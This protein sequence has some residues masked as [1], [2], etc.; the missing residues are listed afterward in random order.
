MSACVSSDHEGTH[1]LSEPD[2]SWK[3]AKIEDL[4]SEADSLIADKKYESAFKILSDYDSDNE[5]P[6]IVIKKAE[7]CINYYVGSIMYEIFALADLEKDQDIM[8]LRE[9]DGNSFMYVFKVREVLNNLIEKYPDNGLLYKALGS[10]YYEVF[11]RYQDSWHDTKTVLFF[12]I[13]DNYERAEELNQ[14]DY[15]SYYRTGF[16]YLSLED[17]DKAVEY[18]NKSISLNENYGDSHYH[19]AAAYFNKFDFKPALEHALAAVDIYEDP[20]CKIYALEMAGL[21]YIQLDEVENAVRCYKYALELNSGNTSSVKLLLY[22]Y[23]DENMLKESAELIS[24]FVV[25]YP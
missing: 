22:I 18:F 20:S 1:R 25:R 24:D 11:R 6:E 15:L 9:R 7:I 12:S 8:D 21:I 14:Y 13:I 16:C 4:L 23:I 2:N 10:Y 3:D 5:I 19:L 17:N